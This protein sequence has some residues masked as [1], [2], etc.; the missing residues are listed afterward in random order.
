MHVRSG[1]GAW[2]WRLG[3]FR[4]AAMQAGLDQTGDVLM[5]TG[6]PST[7][8]GGVVGTSGD[9]PRPRIEGVGAH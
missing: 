9:P 7:S 5:A 2:A 3:R 4:E 6:T 8:P 1:G